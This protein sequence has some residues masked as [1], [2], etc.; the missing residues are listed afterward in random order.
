VLPA[1]RDRAVSFMNATNQPNSTAPGDNVALVPTAWASALAFVLSVIFILWAPTVQLPQRCWCSRA[2]T[3]PASD[4]LPTPSS[5]TSAAKCRKPLTLTLDYGVAPAVA[6]L[7]LMASTAQAPDVLVAGIV[8]D[9]TIR[10][11]SILLIFF[12]L[13]YVCI[14]LDL[15]GVFK[16][17]ALYAALRAG[18]SPMRLL[19]TFFGVASALTTVTSNDIVILTLTPIIAAFAAETGL[20]PWPLLLAQFYA[21][22]LC[23]ILLLIGNPTN[24]IIGVAAGIGFDAYVRWMALPTLAA[25]VTCALAVWLMFRRQLAVVHVRVPTLDP[26]AAV[27]DPAGALFGSANLVACLALLAA[28]AWVGADMGYITAACGGVALT[29]DV[30]ADIAAA[31]RAAG[32]RCI[33][34][35]SL[36]TSATVL[37]RMPWKLLPFV[38]A[39]FTLVEAL[40]RDGWVGLIAGALGSAH[41]R[42]GAVGAPLLMMLL[43]VLA[44]SAINNQPM[45]ILFTRIVQHPGFTRA[46]ATAVPAGQAASTY[47]AITYSLIAGSNLGANL[48]LLGALAGLMWQASAA[49]KGI[50][51]TYWAFA[52]PGALVTPVVATVTALVLASQA[53]AGWPPMDSAARLLG[54]QESGAG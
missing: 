19:F 49:A 41:A 6:V 39:M 26:R 4:T 51:V 44:C 27:T 23:S 33:C 46:L 15:T 32:Q 14:S 8:G 53:A 34:P 40:S 5:I 22:N 38:V 47:T 13:A 20:D 30:V 37:A 2:A 21:A 9:A 43:S 52:R 16:A 17:V 36:P 31:R 7:V 28:S 42:A 10:P 45:S 48:T 29:R 24:V 35:R 18:G 12:G 11:W 25:V 54:L 50:S 3:A 1:Y